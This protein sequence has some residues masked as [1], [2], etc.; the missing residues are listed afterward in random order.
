MHAGLLCGEAL[1]LER[2]LADAVGESRRARLAA[3]VR[4][5]FGRHWSS[6]V[7]IGR[8]FS[9]YAVVKSRHRGRHFANFGRHGSSRPAPAAVRK[10]QKGNI[11]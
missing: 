10:K 3:E 2:R 1:V 6:F 8:H 9:A 5:F 11:G 7:V 4:I